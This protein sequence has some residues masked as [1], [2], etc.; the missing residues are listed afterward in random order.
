MRADLE[1]HSVASMGNDES[2]LCK[3][4]KPKVLKLHSR[5]TKTATMDLRGNKFKMTMG[6]TRGPW[7]MQWMC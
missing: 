6:V 2:P 7:T 1:G 4:D 3:Q 5:G